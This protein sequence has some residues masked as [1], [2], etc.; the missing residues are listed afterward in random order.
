MPNTLA[1][2]LASTPYS[3]SQFADGDKLGLVAVGTTII[4][5]TDTGSGWVELGR[6]TDTTYQSAGYIGVRVQNDGRAKSFGGG[7]LT[8]WVLVDDDKA[9]I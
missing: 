2:A 8:V 9:S 4:A 7:N 5:Y 6:A 3:V 1:T